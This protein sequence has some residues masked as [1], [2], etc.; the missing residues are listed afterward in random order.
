M[1]DRNYPIILGNKRDGKPN[2]LVLGM[3][4][5]SMGGYDV[6]VLGMKDKNSYTDDCSDKTLADSLDGRVYTTLHF[7][8]MEALDK[9][10]KCLQDTR[11]LWEKEKSHG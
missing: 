2:K 3:K 6:M 1:A 10:I 4:S 7:C 8:T 5:K 11:K 9:M